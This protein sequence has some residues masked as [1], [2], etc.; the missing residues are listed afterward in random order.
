MCFPV[1]LLWDFNLI[2]L[3]D[4]HIVV[5]FACVRIKI[6]CYL[7]ID[8]GN[9]NV[10]FGIT[11]EYVCLGTVYENVFRMTRIANAADLFLAY[12]KVLSPESVLVE[13]GYSSV[14]LNC[15]VV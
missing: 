15:V 2:L 6:L 12:M 8:I 13:T 9:R 3:S 4:I 10:K 14:C 7:L 5:S 11:V 1:L